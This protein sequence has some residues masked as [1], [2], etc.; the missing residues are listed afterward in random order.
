MPDVDG[1]DV[2]FSPSCATVALL[3]EVGCH[4]ACCTGVYVP[5][6]LSDPVSPTHQPRCHYWGSACATSSLDEFLVFSNGNTSQWGPRKKRRMGCLFVFA[7][8]TP[9][10]NED[11]PLLCTHLDDTLSVLA[12]LPLQ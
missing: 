5:F 12:G 11:V 1:G 9:A 4:S 6:V 8:Q 2:L 3:R 7:P 10:G